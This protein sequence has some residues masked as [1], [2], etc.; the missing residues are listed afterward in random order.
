MLYLT[1]C[2]DD[3][4]YKNT[5]GVVALL[6]I[7]CAEALCG[8]QMFC[9]RRIPFPDWMVCKTSECGIRFIALVCS[10]LCGF[11]VLLCFLVT[12][13]FLFCYYQPSDWL[14]RL[15]Q[16]LDLIGWA[17]HLQNDPLCVGGNIQ[18]CHTIWLL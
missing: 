17:D 14:R 13:K 11:F 10:F 9:M 15:S 6:C 1:F 8:L 16:S 3:L 12:V 18:P 4:C 5:Q 2:C 7:V